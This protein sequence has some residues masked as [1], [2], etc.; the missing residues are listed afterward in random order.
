MVHV[1][2][3][4]VYYSL[5]QL[6]FDHL[7][8][9]IKRWYP[10]KSYDKVDKLSLDPKEW[11]RH[12]S[13]LQNHQARQK[14]IA[15]VTGGN[16][17][18]GVEIVKLLASLNFTIV[19]IGNSR[20]KNLSSESAFVECD[21]SDLKEV[22]KAADEILTNF[23]HIDL[24]ICNAAV[25]LDPSSNNHSA[26]QIEPHLMVNV[27]SPI[28][29]FNR[30][31]RLLEASPSDQPRAIFVSSVTCHA[32]SVE[33]FTRGDGF[34]E[35]LWHRHML[36]HKSYADSKLLLSLYVQHLG[37]VLASVAEDSKIKV[38]SVHPGI[39]AG[40]IYRHVFLPL[41]FVI[42]YILA[43]FLRS[44]RLAAVHVLSLC[45]NENLT[46]GA[47][48]E[49]GLPV[50]HMRKSFGAFADYTQEELENL[51][52]SIDQTIRRCV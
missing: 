44:A 11:A 40:K 36:G 27:L 42:N 46:N 34:K 31:R 50:K 37:M 10:F 16:G 24:L 33:E 35:E 8:D 12:S 7:P 5:K 26:N 9:C 2:W 43:P 17:T 28:Y 32:G 45:F 14:L 52:E 29:L 41:R 23:H 3:I 21:L 38:G 19:A 49:H 20:P 25:M 13:L 15:V 1:Y 48:Y 51:A 22:S 30:L 18:I 39:V 4:A 6:L 47:Y